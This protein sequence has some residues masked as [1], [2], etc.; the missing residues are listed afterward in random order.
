[1]QQMMLNMVIL[2]AGKGTR[3]KSKMIK[4]AHRLGG[5]PMVSH[6]VK[7]AHAIGVERPIVVVGYDRERVQQILGDGIDYVHQAEQLGTGHAVMQAAPLLAGR[8]GPT[9]VISGDT[10]LLRVETMQKLIQM[11]AENSAA[12]TLLTVMAEDPTG[13]GRIIRRP[14]GMV[15]RIVEHKDAT[16]EQRLVREINLSTYCFD[17]AMLVKALAEI[18]NDNAQGEYYLTD[19]IEIL[20]RLGYPVVTHVVDDP[21]ETVM[22]NDRVQMA[23]A[24]R[25]VRDRIRERLMLSGVT[26]V[27]PATTF[28]DDEVVIG[29]DT[30]IHPFTIVRGRSVIGSDC[31]VGPFVELCDARVSDGERITSQQASGISQQRAD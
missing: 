23:A 13:Y 20:S 8:T 1:M 19:C 5:R 14:D 22:P 7:L 2:A 17:T 26:L 30:I 31:E 15:D 3:M 29:A 24:E 4:V 16:A 18:D 27:D 21:T 9:I 12:A 11:H 28:I 10:P 6:V 25:I